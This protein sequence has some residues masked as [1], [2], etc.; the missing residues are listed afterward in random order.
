M[1][2]LPAFTREGRA[3]DSVSRYGVP[4]HYAS[5]IERAGKEFFRLAWE[6]DLEGIVAKLK[7]GAYGE[8][9]YKIRNPGYS[10]YEGRRELF[11]KRMAA[12][13]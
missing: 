9:W 3:A 2:R 13:R 7:H 11:E 5:H 8:R 12:A 6:Q 1:E 10:Q 4:L